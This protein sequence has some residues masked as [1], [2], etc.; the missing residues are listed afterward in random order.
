MKFVVH[1]KGKN[2][3]EYIKVH[4]DEVFVKIKEVKNEKRTSV[5]KS[6]HYNTEVKSPYIKDIF[7]L[8]SILSD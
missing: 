5:S 7:T 4:A 3:M 6:L 8:F 1:W 2:Q